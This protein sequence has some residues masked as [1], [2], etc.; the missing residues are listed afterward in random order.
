MIA[1]HSGGCYSRPWTYHLAFHVLKSSC[2][3]GALEEV[4]THI[5]GKTNNRLAAFSFVN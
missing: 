2:Y 5:V 1:E 4:Q 3:V